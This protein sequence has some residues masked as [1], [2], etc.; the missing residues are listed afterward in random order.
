MKIGIT[1]LK[2]LQIILQELPVPCSQHLTKKW[3]LIISTLKHH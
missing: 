3:L 1:Y 2:S